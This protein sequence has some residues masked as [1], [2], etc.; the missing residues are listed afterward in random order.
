MQRQP[1]QSSLLKS[2]GYSP[3]DETLE[4]EFVKGGV[5][6][7][8]QVSSQ[9]HAELM[10]APSLGSH[11]ARNIRGQYDYEKVPGKS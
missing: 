9:T 1:V 11:F 7:Y 8:K 6:K 5:Y 2:V 10:S 3:E 4:V